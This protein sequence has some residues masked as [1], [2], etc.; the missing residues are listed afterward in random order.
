MK[1]LGF[2]TKLEPY[3]SFPLG[4]NDLKPVEMANAYAAFAN[5][6][7]YNEYTILEKVTDT[8]GKT[9]I[10]NTKRPQ[11]KVLNAIA[12]ERLDSILQNVVTSGTGTRAYI[13]GIKQGAKTGTTSLNADVWFVGYTKGTSNDI[14]TAVW[15][16]NDDY[17]KKLYG[18]ATGGT[19]AAP[20][21]RTFVKKYYN[22]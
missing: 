13:S 22:K 21:Y 3:P 6:G 14:A 10:D 11:Q 1:K 5:G 7:Y 16:G 15:L 8:S 17:H 9:W 20:V 12:V 19:W 4:S 18:G 2:T